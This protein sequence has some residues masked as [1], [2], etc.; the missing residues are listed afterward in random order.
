[1]ADLLFKLRIISPDE[2]SAELLR[3]ALRS[4]FGEALTLQ[5]GRRGNNPK[6]AGRAEVLSY[7]ELE[8]SQAELKSAAEVQPP[9]TGE[10]QRLGP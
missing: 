9:A 5:R 7:G 10:T 6:Y 8:L 4:A 3:Q 2:E 1:M